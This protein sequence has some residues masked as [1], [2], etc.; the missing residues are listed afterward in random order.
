MR[1]GADQTV[2][3]VTHRLADLHSLDLD[4]II[5]LDAGRVVQ[6]GCPAEVVADP[7]APY[8]RLRRATAADVQNARPAQDQSLPAGAATP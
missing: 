4:E 5:V 7:D 2:V 6:R 3:L 1:A 8:Q